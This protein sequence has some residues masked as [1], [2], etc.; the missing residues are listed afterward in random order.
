MRDQEDGHPARPYVLD[1]LPGVPA[2]AGVEARRQ[3]VEDDDPGVADERERDE[4]ALFLATGELAEPGG[5]PV[6]QAEAF[7]Q[8][9]PVGRTG[10][11]GRVQL[12]CLADGQFGLQFALLELGA[13]DPAGGL[14]VGDRVEAGDSDPARVGHPQALDALDG[15]GLSGA[16]RAEDP[17]DL[18]LLDGE[19]DAVHDRPATVGLAQFTHF[20]DG[21][22]I[23][24]AAGAGAAHRP[25]RSDRH[26]PIG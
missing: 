1:E 15:G 5:E 8:R 17:E 6:G 11:E 23:R 21:H 7:G 12:Q 18:A 2:G 9:A 24:F 20:D 4:Q 10:I 19:G 25:T 22:G 3:F 16:V 26:Q 14:V 13:Q